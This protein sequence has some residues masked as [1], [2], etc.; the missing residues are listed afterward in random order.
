MY[1]FPEYNDIFQPGLL[2]KFVADLH[3]GKLHWD[4]HN[5]PEIPS[6]H[7]ETPPHTNQPA[8]QIL[9]ANDNKI[10]VGI[11]EP[12]LPEST[13]IKLAPSE[14]RYTLLRNEL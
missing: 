5:E 8:E 2:K 12:T 11:D 4:F 1:L 13:F 3:S 6:E 10:D 9:N 7:S 14:K